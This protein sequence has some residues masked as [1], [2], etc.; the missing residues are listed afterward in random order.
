MPQLKPHETNRDIEN[1][2]R[3]L[4]VHRWSDHPEVNDFIG[5]IY[6]EHI[7]PHLNKSLHAKGAKKM[8]KVLLLDLYCAWIDD[9]TMSIAWSRMLAHY[10]PKSIYNKLHITRKIIDI[11]DLCS[12]AGL[13]NHVIGF[14]D[15]RDGGQSRSPKMWPTQKLV[16]EFEKA[17]FNR[18]DFR[19]IG[20]ETIRL[21]DDDKALVEYQDTPT[22][23]KMRKVLDQ[24]NQLL[25]EHHIDLSNIDRPYVQSPR[26]KKHKI[27]KTTGKV[28]AYPATELVKDKKKD[29][30]KTAKIRKL[31]INQDH[32]VY[33]VFNN[34]WSKG[35]RFYGGFWQHIPRDYRRFIRINGERTIEVDFSSHH[36]VLV[37]AMAGINY[38]NEKGLMD[39]PYAIEEELEKIAGPIGNG[40]RATV[41]KNRQYSGGDERE[42]IKQLLLT[43]LNARSEKDTIMAARKKIYQSAGH[44]NH[45]YAK[46]TNELL[47]T[48]LEAIKLKHK[49]I[50]KYLGSNASLDLQYL[51]SK[52]SEAIILDFMKSGIPI[53]SVHDSYIVWEKY[54]DDLRECMNEEWRKFSGLP[55]KKLVEN[56]FGADLPTTINIKQ[57]GYYQEEYQ[58]EEEEGGSLHQE[59]MSIKNKEHV[60][61]RHENEL[62]KFMLWRGREDNRNR[63]KESGLR[64][65]RYEE[66]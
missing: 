42:L 13:I 11:V 32:F 25:F 15:R 51:D 40:T 2:W 52:I 65:Q 49:P 54:A 8:L 46:L 47:Y 10:K 35:G 17:A 4:D 16:A 62:K 34:S 33:R 22:V 27:N 45:N 63:I 29:K 14:Y 60:S 21:H 7:T 26:N 64:D 23:I 41:D 44:Y 20:Q 1:H 6:D 36:A 43:G 61:S 38:W 37:Y 59:I 3:R 53:L 48:Y 5:R 24:Y 28:Y 31:P 9:P 18:F 66:G 19:S 57:K 55:N 39:D 58:P 50:K 56:V 30:Y 12:D